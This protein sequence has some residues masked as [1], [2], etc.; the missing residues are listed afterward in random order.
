MPH[1]RQ[2]EPIAARSATG[3][4]FQN[5]RSPVFGY[6]QITPKRRTNRCKQVV[7]TG[8]TAC[9]YHSHEKK[10][11]LPVTISIVILSKHIINNNRNNEWEIKDYRK[12]SI[13]TSSDPI[14]LIKSAST[15]KSSIRARKVRRASVKR[16]F[17]GW[18]H[19]HT[20]RGCIRFKWALASVP[21]GLELAPRPNALLS[22][23]SWRD[24]GVYVGGSVI[25]TRGREIRPVT[26]IA[27]T[28][29][30][31]VF[32][33]CSSFHTF[34]YYLKLVKSVYFSRIV[35]F[36]VFIMF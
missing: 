20:L 27:G 26:L 10:K 8:V 19:T 31:R 14:S 18:T 7:V 3:A 13:I 34:E 6:L 15:Q 9:V 17:S 33:A 25:L 5:G 16:D 23:F 29:Y 11:Y 22:E 4:N 28:W 36:R 12:E 1:Q 24:C 30:H 21:F 2:L 32:H 35:Y